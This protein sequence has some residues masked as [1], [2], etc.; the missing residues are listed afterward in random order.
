MFTV[1]IHS[2]LL[3]NEHLYKHNWTLH[4]TDCLNSFHLVLFLRFCLV[5]SFEVY[6]PV[7]LFCLTFYVHLYELGKTSTSFKLG[8]VALYKC[9]P[10]VDCMCLW[11]WLAGWSYSRHRLFFSGHCTP[12]TLLWNGWSQRSHKLGILRH[13]L[14]RVSWQD[15]WAELSMGYGFQSSPRCGYPGWTAE[16]TKPQ[17]GGSQ[18]A[19]CR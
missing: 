10:C 1:F 14:Q 4:H 8:G 3:P 16:A 17:A 11:L 5:P 6:F 15:G 13:L 2:L 18:G 9:V 19:P 12:V 7:F